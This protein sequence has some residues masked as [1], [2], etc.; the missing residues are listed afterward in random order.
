MLH[1]ID[2]MS[3]NAAKIQATATVAEAVQLMKEQAC[4]SLIVDR[5]N[6]QDSYGILTETDIL[7]KGVAL[8]KNLETTFVAELMTKP[9]IVIN[10]AATVEE[11]AQLFAKH[12]LLRAPVIQD[13]QVGMIS[14]SELLR[15]HPAI[16]QPHLEAELQQARQQA[17]QLCTEQG[18]RSP[19]C[20]AAWKTIDALQ[21][22]LSEQRIDELLKHTFEEYCE[23]FPKSP[24]SDFYTNLCGG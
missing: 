3:L 11:V 8:G 2:L 12:R 7:Y 4:R 18:A 21:A 17:N 1:A 5:Q 22:E 19:A 14:V 6:E 24:T 16:S 9:C 13:Q 20:I 23:E 10:P 15:H